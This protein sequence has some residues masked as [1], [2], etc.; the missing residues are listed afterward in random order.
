MA[1]RRDL[2]LMAVAVLGT[3]VAFAQGAAAPMAA[4]PPVSASAPAAAPASGATFDVASIRE[5]TTHDQH[6]HSSIYNRWTDTRLTATNVTLRSLIQ[7]STEMPE[8]RI[9][10]GPSW[11]DTTTFD[12]EAKSDPSA[13]EQ[14]GKLTTYQGKAQKQAMIQ[15]LLADRFRLATH[16]ETRELPIYA[17]VVA[18]GGAKL[19]PNAGGNYFG[20]GKGT[21]TVR[22]GSDSLAALADRLAAVVGRVVINRTGMTGQYDMALRWTPDSAV[23]A[24]AALP[25][26]APP[27][28]FTAIQEQLGLKLEPTKGP[29][30]VLVIDHAEMP[31]AN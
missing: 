2:F 30:P 18:K 10:G 28:I 20:T 27:D 14:M 7:F 25:A 9:L 11:L 15:A 3:Q 23:A 24:G 22:G 1:I 6:T 8:S 17:L 29:V 4:T 16:T 31:S 19:N 13:D 26:D 21:I 5:N 12:V